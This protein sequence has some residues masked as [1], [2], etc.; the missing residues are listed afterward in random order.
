MSSLIDTVNSPEKL[1][2]LS[3]KELV[4]LASEI[5]EEIKNVISSNGGHLATN[6]GIVELTLVLHRLFDFK[7]DRLVFD[8]GH[9][10][11]THKIITG[12]R[13]RFSTIRTKNGLSGYPGRKES[14]YDPFNAGHAGTSIS[15]GLGLACGDEILDTDRN[16]VVVIGDGSIPAG[17]SF[18][19]L[20]QL[21]HLQKKMIIVLND[22]EMS[23]SRTVGALAHHLTGIRTGTFYNENK[24]RLQNILKKMPLGK[25]VNEVADHIATSILGGFLPGH[26]FNELGLRYFGPIDGH[27]FP[28]MERVIS[29]CK[30]LDGPI[31]IHAVTNKGHG[32]LPARND[33]EYFHGA[34]PFNI[35]DGSSVKTP[36]RETYSSVFAEKL[37]S[38]ARSNS[39]ISAITAAMS[40]GTGLSVFRKEYPERFFDVGICEQHAVTFGAGLSDAGLKPVVAIY[41][42]FLQR[43]FDQLF[44]DIS[45]QGDIDVLF[46]VDRA[47]LVGSDGFSHHGLYDINMLRPLPGFTLMAPKDG[48]EFE[49]MIEFSVGSKGM[50]AVRYPREFVP[51]TFGNSAIP[52]IIPGKAELLVRGERVVLFAYGAMV[53]RAFE[54]SRVLLEDDIRVSVVNARFAKPIDVSLLQ[55]LSDSHDILITAEDHIKA[56]GFGSAVVEVCVENNIS[57]SCIR[58]LGV[59]D[60]HIAHATRP[61]QLSEAGLDKQGIVRTVKQVLR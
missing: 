28:E 20:N 9:Q 37:T 30:K 7:K 5:R 56:G 6:L 53:S 42:T 58:I 2:D 23:I 43:S 17:M 50:F 12:R 25:K 26:F 61:E 36:D 34:K 24:K 55:E 60:K 44:H 52:D 14:D 29:N 35:D 21:G 59:S 16:I 54:A 40:R 1:K 11:Y 57:F 39:R 8:V 41:S 48:N 27:S 22:N 18:E 15:A 38:I 31:I 47:G 46:A 10:C 51:E 32:Y 45:M 49:K 3:E 33:P 19:G 13:D 4:A